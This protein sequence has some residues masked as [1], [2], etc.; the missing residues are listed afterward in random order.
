M[1]T[2][3]YTIVQGDCRKVLRA[4]APG[5]AQL[6]LTDVPY[7]LSSAEESITRDGAKAISQ[8]FGEWDRD[9]D[10]V[11]ALISTA[12]SLSASVLDRR[13]AAY[14]FTGDALFEH[15]RQC[16]RRAINPTALGFYA[17]AR[18]NP[19]PSVRKSQWISAVDLCVW[20]APAGH[21]FNFPAHREAYNWMAAPVVHHAHR[22]HPNEKPVEVLERIIAAHS[23]PGDL[24]LD[25]FC[26][27]G[28]TG[29]AALRLGR[30]F[31]GI[32]FDETYAAKADKRL[33]YVSRRRTGT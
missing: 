31:F 30:R 19:A 4:I 8:D 32:E 21:R 24:V 1:K 27:T 14:V 18:T 3:T 10:A 9:A 2:D 13:A 22:S 20:A 6:L 28:S 33:A 25:P 15:V 5:S 29:E 12:I 16:L 26:G 7:A 23:Q 17:W 11:R